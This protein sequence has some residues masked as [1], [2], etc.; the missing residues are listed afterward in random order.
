[1]DPV[2]VVL[3][4]FMI[5]LVVMLPIFFFTSKI[6]VP[7]GRRLIQ[8]GMVGAAQSGFFILMFFS[9]KYTTSLNTSVIY[10]LVPSL[11]AI[12]SYYVLKEKPKP[13]HF[14]LLAIGLLATVWVIFE[15]SWKNFTN[16]DFNR[17]DLFF[18]LGCIMLGL[19]TTLLKKF[20]IGGSP[21]D[22][23]F[24]STACA[25]IPMAIYVSIMSAGVNLD[26]VPFDIYLWILYL[27]VLTV[28]TSFVWAFGSPRLGPM[29][30]LSYSYLIPSFVL[31]INWM[32][33]DV[34]PPVVV[35][36]GVLIGFVIMFFLQFDGENTGNHQAV[37]KQPEVK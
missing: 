10:T 18:G 2:L 7:N 26:K 19:Y 37:A 21:I 25:V 13:I 24:W 4:R 9:L 30:T 15:G 20:H 22:I 12:T 32:I 1:M 14:L 16:L 11:G 33:M 28:F 27:A 6:N 31:F 3:L 23:V 36:P 35:L 17:G 29:K 8:F 5:S 34:L